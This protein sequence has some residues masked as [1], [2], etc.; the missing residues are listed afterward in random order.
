[1]ITL[2]SIRKGNPEEVTKNKLKKGD[3]VRNI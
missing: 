2:I 1:M 3:D